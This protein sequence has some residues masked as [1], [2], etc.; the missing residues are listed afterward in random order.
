MSSTLGSSAPNGDRP[1]LKSPD[2]VS[3]L[4]PTDD[5]SIPFEDSAVALASSYLQGL[6]LGNQ[7][8]RVL[9]NAA[10]NLTGDFELAI[11]PELNA[12]LV[13]DRANIVAPAPVTL[14]DVAILLVGLQPDAATLT[15]V[16]LASQGRH[17]LGLEREILPEAIAAPLVPLAATGTISGRVWQDLNADGQL[18]P[19]EPGVSGRTVYLDLDLDGALQEN[20]PQTVTNTKGRYRFEDLSS[21]AYAVTLQVPPQPDRLP[22]PAIV[23][24]T[25]T[26]QGNWPWMAAVVRAGNPAFP[27]HLCGATVVHPEWA[28]TAAHCLFRNIT[29]PLQPN[30]IEVVVGR[31][32]LSSDAGDRIAVAEIAIFPEY[33]ISGRSLVNDIGLIRLQRA[34]FVENADIARPRDNR[35]A[36]APGVSATVLGWGRTQPDDNTSKSDGLQQVTL[37]IASDRACREAYAGR[38]DI[39][40]ASICAGFAE[41]QRDA[42]LGDSGGPLL[43]LS[44]DRWLQVGLVSFG[45]GCAQPNSYGVYTRIADFEAWIVETIGAFLENTR[46]VDISDGMSAEN[47]NIASQ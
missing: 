13:A 26:I 17:L 22:F 46:V 30:E 43:V 2:R 14:T 45:D 20:E 36:V 23:G 5:P 21:G 3:L 18:D 1:P 15:A 10:R 6:A 24:G 27:G 39:P 40:E 8:D 37:P 28:L 42:C 34:T 25:P 4:F 12:S 38:L 35:L 11:A 9:A 16:E 19:N 44:S 47:I 29:I 31:R 33:E 41:G 32:R 7:S